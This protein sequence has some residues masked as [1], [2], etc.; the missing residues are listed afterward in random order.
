[1]SFIDW[2]AA[3]LPSQIQGQN[4]QN[5]QA[6]LNLMQ[7]QRGLRAL[8]GVNIGDPN[9][10][11]SALSGLAGLGMADQAK[12]LLDLSN[13]RAI[14]SKAV[15]LATS[16]IGLAQKQV[17]AAN[18]GGTAPDA[19]SDQ[20]QPDLDAAHRQ[21]MQQGADATKDL[22]SYDDPTLRAAA[23]DVYKQ[24]F[25]KMGIPQQNLDEVFGDLSD[26]GLKAHAD[27]LTAAASG[28][29]T[30]PHPTGYAA[31]QALLNS[32]PI[33]RNAEGTLTGS[34]ANPLVQAAVGKYAGL[35]LGPGMQ[36]ALEETA[37]GRNQ[38]AAAAFAQP[39]SEATARGGAIG[40]GS[41]GS[42]PVSG[43][44]LT[45]NAQGQP[46]AWILPN[47]T[48]QAI[49]GASQASAAGGAHFAPVNVSTGVP[50]QTRTETTE[51]LAQGGPATSATGAQTTGALGGAAANVEQ[52]TNF[53]NYSAGYNT[54]KA[55]LENLRLAA[56]D[57]STG[58]QSTFWG[59][60]GSLAAEYGIKTPLAPT[61]NQ[62]AA[63]EEVQKMAQSVLAQQKDTLGLPNTNQSVT[64]ATGATP[65]ESTSPLGLQ[66][67]AG[68]LEGNEDYINATRQA[69][70]TWKAHG[71]GYETFQQFVPQFMQTFHPQ[72]FQAQY[73]DGPERAKVRQQVGPARFDAEAAAA[74][75]LGYLAGQ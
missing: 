35:D 46:D 47:G 40:A 41:V 56:T 34:M 21:I 54:R 7:Q 3:A 37:P 43:A 58:P 52:A 53:E 10:V 39:T 55:N 1:M 2:N 28:D 57:I 68:V 6:Q 67:L 62:A 27:Y 70:D 60:L 42:P 75:R 19:S 74:K 23:A 26:K 49:Q 44:R 51:Q 24:K 33:Y 16:A 30:A 8:H 5:Q 13:Q 73:L 18:Q 66:R 20:Q 36:Q 64:L 38:A 31:S 50:G 59:R 12:A 9:S 45:F 11:Q 63:Y 29:T 72:V 4:T 61:A 71:N 65:H 17:D 25:A 32:D 48:T 22:L 14:S 69:W 15:P